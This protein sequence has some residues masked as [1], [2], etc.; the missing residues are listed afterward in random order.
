MKK[1][2]S[3]ILALAL[4][5]SCAAVLAEEAP[6]S[7]VTVKTGLTWNDTWGLTVANIVEQDGQVVKILVD[8][9]RDGLSSKEKYNDY[10]IG[11]VSSIGKEWWEQVAFLEDWVRDNGVD[12]VVYDGDGH[13]TVPDVI[14]G[15]TIN[16]ADFT[17]AIQNAKADAADVAEING[18]TVKTGLAVSPTWGPTVANVVLKDGEIVKVLVD[19]VRDG[20]SSKEKFDDYGVKS[21]STLGKEWWE[22]VKSYEE[23]VAANGA[24]KVECDENGHALNPDLI[25]GATI[26]VSDFT[27]A[28]LDA[29]SK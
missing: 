12:E 20:Q 24:D 5:L 23:W 8:V 26:N 19:V 29:L 6:A 11:P 18:Y 17:T 28:V 2:A 21:A 3:L 16:I 14:S 25:S 13:A 22:Q 9:V 27:A 10:G 15:A 7:D 4:M 1:L